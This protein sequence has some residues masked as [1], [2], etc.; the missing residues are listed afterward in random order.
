M[1]K[2]LLLLIAALYFTACNS[3]KID[4]SLIYKV[5][6]IKSDGCCQ[7]IVKTTVPTTLNEPY[8]NIFTAKPEDVNVGDGVKVDSVGHVLKIYKSQF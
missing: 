1:K 3:P 4:I 2:L 8:R 6:E 5:M 7:V